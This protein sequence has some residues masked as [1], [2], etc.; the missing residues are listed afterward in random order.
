VNGSFLALD[1]LFFTSTS[2]KLL[3]G[4]WFPL[5]IATV[6][7][8]LMLTWRKGEHI[9]DAV[10][11]SMRQSVQQLADSLRSDPPVRL[12]GTAV[13]LGRLSQGIPLAL[14][15]NLRYNRVI[16][17]HVLLVA[18]SI[19]EIPR[20]PAA[21][22]AIVSSL[23]EGVTRLELRCG[24]MEHPDVPRG[25]AMASAEGKVD[26]GDERTVIYFTGRETVVPLG[27]SP[28]MSRWRESLFAFMH[29]NSQRPGSY[30]CIPTPQL[31]EIGVEFEI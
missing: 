5:L 14:T 31:L 2:T 26:L 18:V 21:E 12:P 3:E 13:V 17:S 15:Q 9:L 24:F 6:I 29:R 1:L 4:G 20:V 16:H 28:A 19:A 23:C 8:F 30:F 7:S 25:L 22:R 27:R 10:R 11:L